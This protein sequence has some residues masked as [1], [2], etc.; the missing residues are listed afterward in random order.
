MLH[1]LAYKTF[2]RGPRGF[3]SGTAGSFVQMGIFTVQETQ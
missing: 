2:C 1:K 3:T